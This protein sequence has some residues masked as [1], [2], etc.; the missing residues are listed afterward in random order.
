MTNDENPVSLTEVL[1]IA[2]VPLTPANANKVLHHAGMLERRVRDSLKPGNPQKSYWAATDTG[3]FYGI[4]EEVNSL[5]PEPQI[6]YLPSRWPDLWQTVADTYLE[7]L[8]SGE[9]KLRSTSPEQ[10]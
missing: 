8:G 9:I 10:F 7:M 6:R 4:V 1:A 5:S 3:K 2:G